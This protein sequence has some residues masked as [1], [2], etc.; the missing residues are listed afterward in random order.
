MPIADYPLRAELTNEMHARPSLAI[1]APAQVG[2]VVLKA[3]ENAVSRPADEDHRS[4][5]ALAKHYGIPAPDPR[6]NHYRGMIGPASLKWEKHTEVATYTLVRE[7]ERDH[8]FDARI[9]DCLPASW[10]TETDQT[11]LTSAMVDVR[12]WTSEA[13]V[14]RYLTEHLSPDSLVASYIVDEAAMIAGDFR[15]D[16]AG[17]LRFALFVKPD[18]PP[19]RIGRMV[20]RLCEIETYKT[21]SMLGFAKARSVAKPLVELDGR[22]SALL[23]QMESQGADDTLSQLLDISAEIE[24]H[25]SV[26]AFRFSATEAYETIVQQ[27]IESLR[28]TRFRGSQMLREFMIRRY[29]PAMRTVQSTRRKL[30]HMSERASNAAELL[31]TR[32]D[33]DRSAQ[34]QLLLHSMNQRADTQ[35]RLQKTVEGLSVVAIGYYAVSLASYLLAPVAEAMGWDKSVALAIV[36]VPIVA[37][38][39]WVVR[40]IRARH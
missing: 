39:W 34:S 15:M 24:R 6:A 1:H 4:L 20:Q 5:E 32:V 30:D 28:E 27:R 9:F 18:V 29:D 33:V 14:E 22:L 37:T 12:K 25:A 38:V 11:K 16:G 26:V 8:A 31:R 36:A 7:G 2:F 21:L 3:A 17:H 40:S 19:T 23:A 10:A 35:L 13:D